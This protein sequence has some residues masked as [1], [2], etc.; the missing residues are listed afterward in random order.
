MQSQQFGGRSLEE[1]FRDLDTDG[2]GVITREEFE[3][4]RTQNPAF[5]PA[6]P[7]AAAPWQSMRQGNV[8]AAGRDGRMAGSM[9][10]PTM[11]MSA[12]MPPSAITAGN[13]IY[14]KS[15]GGLVAGGSDEE[16]LAMKDTRRAFAL[17]GPILLI[18]LALL[19]A[20]SS[21][22]L[23]NSST[24]LYFAQPGIPIGG[25]LIAFVILIACWMRF[26]LDVKFPTCPF[27][28]PC[29]CCLGCTHCL[30][31]VPVEIWVILL[32]LLFLMMVWKLLPL[33]FVGGFAAVVGWFIGVFGMLW[34]GTSAAASLLAC[35]IACVLLYIISLNYFF[36]RARPEVSRDVP[37]LFTIW[38]VFVLL[39]GASFILFALPISHDAADSHEELV[40]K[41]QNGVRTRNLYITSQALQSLRQTP[42]CT[43]QVTIEDCNGFE[44]TRYAK[45]IKEMEF[46]YKCSGFCYNPDLVDPINTENVEVS[47]LALSLFSKANFAASC[48]GMAARS[49]YNFVGQV[50]KQVFHQGVLL[51][52]VSLSLVTLHLVGF[53]QRHGGAVP[54]TGGMVDGERGYGSM[55]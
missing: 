9:P 18:L 12:S 43:E 28:N 47:K 37:S 1:L 6:Q 48:D 44:M 5:V 32:V 46:E 26:V 34:F 52:V 25:L 49:M 21:L 27:T 33:F 55:K 35:S 16:S 19:P 17:V 3:R 7:G 39:L 45:T 24:Y 53:C 20:W 54:E 11:Q 30:E 2:D 40:S 31:H 4:F 51:L 41:C 38:G 14:A 22:A 36:A 15:P 50:G 29:V 23:L 42:G 13:N 10:P 8:Q